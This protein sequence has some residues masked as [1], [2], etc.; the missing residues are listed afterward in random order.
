MFYLASPHTQEGLFDVGTAEKIWTGVCANGITAGNDRRHLGEA[1]SLQSPNSEG[2][3]FEFLF[4]CRDEGNNFT[5]GCSKS[6]QGCV[7]ISFFNAGHDKIY[8]NSDGQDLSMR[9]SLFTLDSLQYGIKKKMK[10]SK[11]SSKINILPF[12]QK[13]LTGGA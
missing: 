9:M 10:M 4:S 13:T 5:R 2:E 1:K 7:F 8:L 6:R 12:S 11:Y 3:M